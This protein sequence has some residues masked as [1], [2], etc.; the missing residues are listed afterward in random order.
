MTTILT[1]SCADL[2][3]EI[4]KK[5]KIGVIPLHVHLGERSYDDGKT[6]K[7][8]DLFQY[9]SETG[10]LPKTSAVSIK[11]FIEFFNQYED[12]IFIGI[13]EKLSATLQ[14]AR[15]A[16]ESFPQKRITLIDS[17]N[18]SSGIGLLVLHAVDLLSQGKDYDTIVAEIEKT[19][20]KVRCAFIIDTLEYLYK[21]GRCSALTNIVGTLLKIRPVIEVKPNGTLGV[22]EKVTGARKKALDALVLDFKHNLDSIVTDRV[23]IVHTGVPGDVEYLK[24]EITS[25]SNIKEII[26]GIAGATISSHC[27]PGT[28]GI[29]YQL[30]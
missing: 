7:P 4:L 1:D 15:I 26:V 14:S 13:G 29:I 23:F 16:V 20:P 6:I 9:V 30:N 22:R 17:S 3:L 21:G 2:P 10:E 8:N 11:E 5:N 24:K 25:L 19:I 18:L 27:G 12:I 28:I